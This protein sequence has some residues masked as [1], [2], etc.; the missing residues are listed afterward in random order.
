MVKVSS[1]LLTHKPKASYKIH[2]CLDKLHGLLT[3]VSG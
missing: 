2:M 1:V 3:G